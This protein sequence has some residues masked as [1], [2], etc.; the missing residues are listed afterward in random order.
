MELL[1]WSHLVAPLCISSL[2]SVNYT[3]FT[4]CLRDSECEASICEWVIAL[5]RERGDGR[6]YDSLT[7]RNVLQ[8][9]LVELKWVISVITLIRNDLSQVWSLHER[10]GAFVTCIRRYITTS[11]FSRAIVLLYRW[12]SSL[13]IPACQKSVDTDGLYSP[14]ALYECCKASRIRG[15]CLRR[16]MNGEYMTVLFSGLH[17]TGYHKKKVKGDRHEPLCPR[18]TGAQRLP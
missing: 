10:A 6:I 16:V 17:D 1:W 3:W 2:L 13:T 18:L 11:N 7:W 14:R 4:R 12:D 15:L 5:E 9:S 8:L